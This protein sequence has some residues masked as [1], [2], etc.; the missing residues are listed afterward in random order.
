MQRLGRH[1]QAVGSDPL[2]LCD[3]VCVAG[4]QWEMGSQV[5]ARSGHAGSLGLVIETQ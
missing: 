4:P 5:V 3:R 2:V 1:P